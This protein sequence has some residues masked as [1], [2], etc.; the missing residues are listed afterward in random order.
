MMKQSMVG[1]AF[2]VQ[3]KKNPVTKTS[4]LLY[5]IMFNPVK[6]CWANSQCLALLLC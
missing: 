4:I 6:L 2:E 3:L 5:P 1:L